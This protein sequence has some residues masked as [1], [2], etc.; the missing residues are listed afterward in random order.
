MLA[1]IGIVQRGS[2]KNL[3]GV[4]NE[5]ISLSGKIISLS[6]ETTTKET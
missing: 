6:R 5:I 4:S 2:N 1:L 3:T